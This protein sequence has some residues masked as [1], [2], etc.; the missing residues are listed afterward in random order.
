MVGPDYRRP[1]LGLTPGFVSAPATTESAATADLTRWWTGFEDAELTRL[2]D[3]A[4]TLNL[5][6][7]QA[8]LIVVPLVPRQMPPDRADGALQ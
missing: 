6:L 3:R 5:D 8:I 7:A 2:V 4:L 1:R